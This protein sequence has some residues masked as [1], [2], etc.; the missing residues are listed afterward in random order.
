MAIEVDWSDEAIEIF[1]KN[2]TYLEKEWSEKEV[3]RF[4]QQIENIIIRLKKFP[5]SYPQGY[6]NK[7]YRKA[8][9]NKYIALFYSYQKSNNKIVLIS[10][11]NVKQ[12]PG[13]LKY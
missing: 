4:I 7:K 13:K 1:Q 5:Q 6:K 11:W 3:S 12:D 10:F 2:I 9:L 8:R